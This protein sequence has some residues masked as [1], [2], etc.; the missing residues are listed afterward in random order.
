[1]NFKE[2][3]ND[4]AKRVSKQ[5][6]QYII[7]KI[8]KEEKK[9]ADFKLYDKAGL[10]FDLPAIQAEGGREYNINLDQRLSTFTYQLKQRLIV[11]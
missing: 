1:M 9:Q 4:I 2:Y 11:F 3:T 8:T 6:Q 10:T 7:L 5:Q